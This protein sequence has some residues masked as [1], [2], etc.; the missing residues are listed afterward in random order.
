MGAEASPL[1]RG[2]DQQGV[3]VTEI[4]RA[5]DMLLAA[6]ARDATGALA[7]AEATAPHL[8]SLEARM[9]TDGGGP[10]P[11]LDAF[12][13]SVGAL[14]AAP[15]N[16]GLRCVAVEFGRALTA[17]V[18]DLALSVQ[19]LGKGIAEEQ[20]VAL[21]QANRFL[22]ELADLQGSLAVS[23]GTGA[24]NPLLD[25]RDGLLQDL[26]GLTDITVT[27]AEGGLAEVRLGSQPNGPLL[28]SGPQAPQRCK[29]V[30]RAVYWSR[31]P[32]SR[33]SP[34]KAAP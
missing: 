14:S 29:R 19:T 17:S 4:R 23:K 34:R 27:M 22:S 5:F 21:G 15:D 31:G 26:A 11:Q 24:R 28:L 6:R 13:D 12:F 18:A 20:G 33:A 9:I 32:S 2:I 16:I 8:R 7:G 10:L 3:Q 30:R 25:R 1:L